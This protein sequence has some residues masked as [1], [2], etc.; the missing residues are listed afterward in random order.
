MSYDISLR[1]SGF[2]RR[3]WLEE[4]RASIIENPEFLSGLCHQTSD[5]EEDLTDRG[6]IWLH[7]W[8]GI[9]GVFVNL[10]GSGTGLVLP[11]G[12]SRADFRLAGELVRLALKH[13]ASAVDENDV[14][15]RGTEDE[16]VATHT[17]QAEF[18]HA[19]LKAEDRAGEFRFPVGPLMILLLPGDAD[20]DWADLELKLVERM[21][22]YGTAFLASRMQ[23]RTGGE[24]R[25]AA[26]YP[27]IP[28][29]MAADTQVVFLGGEGFE[30]G[31]TMVPVESFLAV[32]GE[33][34]E[35]LGDMIYVPP[36]TP[37]MMLPLLALNIPLGQP[38]TPPPGV[39]GLSDEDWHTLAKAPC[40]VFLLIASADGEIDKKELV[41]FAKTLDGYGKGGSPVIAQ[42]KTRVRADFPGLIDELKDG[43]FGVELMAVAALLHS[44]KFPDAD[45]REL[46]RFLYGLGE[47][48]ASASGGFF[49]FGSKIGKKERERLDTLKSL[50]AL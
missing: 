39:P 13:G 29:L 25:I 26:A 40:L 32:F 8:D 21:N 42:I 16:V 3:A 4:I 20:G 19:I 43:N 45:S 35:R 36:A 9:R 37:D 18:F 49:G 12:S 1:G 33:G 6:Q 48:V 22:R 2:N 50:L 24:T 7:P 28:T 5:L 38:A 27:Q 44:G 17:R 47:A 11:A 23:F 41:S 10:D 30:A 15:L 31:K 46:A 14:A 34:V